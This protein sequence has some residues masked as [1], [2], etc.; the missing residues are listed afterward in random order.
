MITTHNQV[1]CG[2]CCAALR[3][4]PANS[5]DLVLTSPPYFQQREYAGGDGI[6]NEKTLE[7]YIDN[8]ISVFQECVRV[9]KPTGTLVFNVGDKY[10]NGN[11]L[12]VPYRFAIEVQKLRSVKLINELTWVKIN[13][14]PKQDPRE[15]IPSTE[16]FFIFAKSNDYYFNREA[17]LEYRDKYCNGGHRNSGNDIGK[18]YYE[19]IDNSE[20]SAEQKKLAATEL[21]GVIADVK[22]GK[23]ESFRMKIK[24]IHA[25]PYDGLTGGRL[26]QLETKG[27]TIIKIYGN[28]IRRDIIESTVESIKGNIHPAVYPEFI[29]QEIIKLLTRENDV[30]L[31]PFLGSGTTAVVAKC[32]KRN[33]IG[34]E[35]HSEYIDYAIRRIDE[36]QPHY[37]CEY[38][39]DCWSGQTFRNRI[40]TSTMIDYPVYIDDVLRPKNTE[41]EVV[42]DLFAGCGGLSLGFEAAGYPTIGYEMDV[43]ACGTYNRNL[44]GS[45]HNVKL[46]EGFNYPHADIVI[47]GPPCQPFSKFGF[48]NQKGS[49]DDRDGFPIVIDAIRRVQPKIFLFENVRGLLY[50]GGYF[51]IILTELHRL[52]YVVEYQLL[53]AANYGVPQMRERLFVVGHRSEYRFPKPSG[54]KVTVRDAI[55]DTMLTASESS[56]FLT[57]S[58][59]VYV[60]KYEKASS[61]INPRDLN[62]D[63]PA[64]TLTCR[65]I[66]ATTADM[67]RIKLPDGRR[68]R[69]SLREAARLQSFPDWFEFSGNEMQ[70]FYQIGNAVPPLLA[71]QLAMSIKDCCQSDKKL[72]SHE[73][74]ACTTGRSK[75][76]SLF[77][78]EEVYYKKH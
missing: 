16:P 57:A 65:N 78:N 8:I 76:K 30:V 69:L 59:D 45:C 40:V 62:F 19:L 21:G 27:F 4:I 66:A 50:S 54:K 43:A 26:T 14:A 55:G 36:T 64:R 23:L 42:L 47:G 73:V 46:I 68:R 41:R 67:H 6:G 71:Y 48:G 39:Y 56:K 18:K 38:L 20:L 60:A 34:I 58:M 2:D 77:H 72:T 24:G 31:D 53:N 37:S 28:S 74:M 10:V 52:G 44:V 13:P 29:V 12:L 61:C 63:K 17:F 3:E 33:Y 51:D 75:Q 70:R 35:I 22:M 5:I 49:K 1:I 25:L 11:L 15:L 9:I 32:L 7:T